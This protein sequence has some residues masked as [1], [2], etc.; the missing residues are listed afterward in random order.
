MFRVSAITL[1]AALLVAGCNRPAPTPRH[2]D[3]P[4]PE[5]KPAQSGAVTTT[6]YETAAT[7]EPLPDD[8]KTVAA[9]VAS[10]APPP[11]AHSYDAAML[12][13]LELLGEKKYQPALT[14]FEKARAIQDTEQV[15]AE[16]DRLKDLLARQSAAER[17]L[18]DIRAVLADGK[19]EDASRLI[20]A[21]LEQFG[22]SDSAEEL[23]KLKRQ[24]DALSSDRDTARRDRLRTEARAALQDN[25]L[26]AAALSLEAALQAG[27]DAEMQKTYGEVRERLARY[28]AGRQKAAEL[29]RDPATLEDALAAL[30]D[31]AKAWD[32]PQVRQDLDDCS[33]A[34]QK[35][36]DR[37]SVA[38]FEVRGEVGL[39]AAGRAIAEE[40]LPAFKSRYDLVERGQL[41]RVLDEL[42]LQA[43][44]LDG[45]ARGQEEVG[46]LARIRYLV[47]GSVTPLNG[48][49]VQARVVEVKTGLVVQ[50]ARLT[51]ANVEALL[52][53]LPQLAQLL[54][55]TDDQKLAFESAFAAKYP[56][57]RPVEAAAPLPPPPPPAPTGPPPPP[58]V[59]YTPR[60]PA[61]GG[62]VVA[63]FYRLPV[64]VA[65]PPPV[66]VAVRD[67]PYHHRLVAVSLEL[68][69]NCFRR[70]K[71]A[72]AFRHFSVALNI[73]GPRSEIQVRLG[74]VTP[75]L[76]AAVVAAPPPVVVT[77]APVVVAP[78]PVFVA[79]PRLAV[80]NFVLN[81]APGLVPPATGDWAADHFTSYCG[82]T[83][84]IVE[85][86][87][88][89]WYMGRLGITMRDVLNNANARR[90]LA[91]ALNVRFF[92]FGTIEQTASFNVT[93]H[94]VDAESGARTGT[95]MIHVQDQAEMK[96][97]MQELVRQTGAGKAEQT[98]L[99]QEGK[100]SEKTLTA[101]RQQLKAGN[102]AAAAN[103]A[104]TALQ[105]SP[106]NV[107]LQSVLQQAEQQQRQAELQQQR[108]RD[109]ERLRADAEKARK[110]QEELVREA[111][112]ARQRAEAEAKSR[113]AAA[114]KAEE[115]RKARAVTQLRAT[116][117]QATQ[118]GDFAE[119]ARVLQSAVALQPGGDV[120]RE[121]AQAKAKSE[122]AARAR[123]AADTA[124]REAEFKQQREA[125]A[126]RVEEERRRREAVEAL[127]RKAQAEEAKVLAEARQKTELAKR[128]ADQKLAEERARFAK[129]KADADARQKM[130]LAKREADQK[131]AEERA[132]LAKAK[133]DADARQKMELAKAKTDAEARSK[134]A[135]PSRPRE[136]YELALSAG[137][138]A[139]DK[140]NLQGAVNA[141]REA[142]RL[143][144]G[145]R[146]ATVRLQEAQR[147]L[148][149]EAEAKRKADEG[150]RPQPLPKAPPTNA[151][152]LPGDVNQLLQRGAELEKRGAH[153]QAAAIYRQALK[154]AP[155]NAAANAALRRTEFNA[156]MN[157]GKQALA[158]RR[159]P[160]A[161]KSFEAALK[162]SPENA[163]AKAGL[164]KARDRKP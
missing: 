61:F 4:K 139:L 55:M 17:T 119:A 34:L 75:H 64:V 63:D 156:Q 108:R 21:A 44:E 106:R 82:T 161:V 22:G 105:A 99:V 154:L 68:G 42:R 124:K 87:E 164:Q 150:N 116:A 11:T 37:L 73:G 66:V 148:L 120:A 59:T 12:E 46:R 97:R 135:P 113:D 137:K 9:L 90:C 134:S 151:S 47:L 72:D 50:T 117:A 88:V 98:R 142:L 40:L 71:F 67:D 96:L 115:D 78:A 112:A 45:N 20:A 138:S 28:D 125:A 114:R 132:R 126:A 159:F 153:N 93:A 69:D 76:P 77:P 130:E 3:V 2:I 104:R 70:G 56:E 74:N 94:L 118:K 103:L 80:F 140:K 162:I 111:Q 30:Q 84:E 163:E 49:T 24:A 143:M 146:E 7:A 109:E 14:A 145:D 122:E 35:R 127:R 41:N 152:P 52:P 29:R 43:G 147:Q 133:A 157:A 48:V 25:N 89:C 129:A 136:D 51:A 95:G 128:E 91:Q 110:R 19:A 54:M 1:L 36:R 141:Y 38:D 123:A 6:A 18:Q 53:R 131:L 79:R 27:D 62:L 60:P 101:A 15:R 149:A 92:L 39:P 160:D 144:P 5:A 32:T 102:A 121:L 81:C 155:G 10:L 16:I 65:P 85:R 83:Y 158:G 8:A 58:I 31:A 57:V 86:G 100:D 13:G 26:R 33:L 107:A 23:A